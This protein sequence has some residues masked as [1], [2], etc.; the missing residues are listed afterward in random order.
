MYFK[1]LNLVRGKEKSAP[2]NCCSPW[3]F[4]LIKNKVGD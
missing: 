3:N 4:I 2:F 1:S